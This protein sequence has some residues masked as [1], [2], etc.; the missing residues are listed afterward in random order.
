MKRTHPFPPAPF[1]SHI[2][3]QHILITT[4]SSPHPPT[5]SLPPPIQTYHCLC[6]TILLAT[7]YP[8]SALPRRAPPSL[9]NAHILPLPPLARTTI[10]TTATIATPENTEAL[11]L[12]SLLTQNM[13][14]ARKVVVVRR[15]DGFEKRRVFRCG[16]CG[17]GVGYEILEGGEEEGV[18]VEK[19]RVIYLLEGGLVETGR[20]GEEDAG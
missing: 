2:H 7:P 12:P 6:S 5:M 14:P 13:R 4:P 9:D 10:T 20:L 16:R 15:E 3:H 11:P 18:G 1:L 19:G 17:V 8:L